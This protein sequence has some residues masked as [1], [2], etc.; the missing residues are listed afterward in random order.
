MDIIFECVFEDGTNTY[1]IAFAK[2]GDLTL[3]LVAPK[4]R[5]DKGD[6][7]IDHI[8]F[9]VDDLEGIMGILKE[10]GI[11]LETVEPTF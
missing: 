7:L 5:D 11:E 2:L 6:V 10:K 9:A 1:T 3:E 8:A 4:S